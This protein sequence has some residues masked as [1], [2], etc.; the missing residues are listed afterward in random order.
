MSQNP[1]RGGGRMRQDGMDG[2]TQ[3]DVR[4]AIQE[5][6][7]GAYVGELVPFP[8]SGGGRVFPSATQDNPI[9]IDFRDGETQ[10][11]DVGD[12]QRQFNTLNRIGADN[13][14][15]GTV[16]IDDGV[17]LRTFDRNNSRT[18]EFSSSFPG[19]VNFANTRVAIIELT[20]DRPFFAGGT[21]STALEMPVIPEPFA[22]T[23]GR[24]GQQN[25]TQDS[26]T[27]VLFVPSLGDT[28]SDLNEP[29]IEQAVANHG[30]PTINTRTVQ[31][32]GFI[33]ENAGGNAIDVLVT[34]LDLSGEQ[35]IADP[36]IHSNTDLTDANSFTVQGNDVT[37]RESG[38][39]LSVRG[40]RVKN[41]TGGN[42]SE[43][44]IQYLGQLPGTR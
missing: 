15:S 8:F 7:R 32:S 14:F 43:V 36:D 9:R 41:D 1:R 22:L 11:P 29:S 2:L 42:S 33:I 17:T 35:I 21:L 26:F 24:F 37:Y 5:G 18:G 40:V 34:A 30:D 16:F 28:A 39:P 38:A 19:Y 44:R 20:S 27:N 4:L 10:I 31:Q 12:A 13:A 23:I 3:E 25:P 6:V